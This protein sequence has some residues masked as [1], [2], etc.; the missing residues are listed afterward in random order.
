MKKLT[1]LEG[2]ALAEIASRGA[3]TSYV[4]AQTFA[5]SP[6]EFWSGSA[7]ALYPLIKRL[8]KRGLLKSKR[9]A[10]GKRQR[11]DY[12]VTPSGRAALLRWLLDAER[13][14]GMGFDPLRTRLVY[15]QLVKSVQRKAFLAQ[16]RTLSTAFAEKPAFE[17]LPL[18]QN[19]HASWLKARAQWLAAL[20]FVV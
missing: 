5:R 14:A 4:V 18:T 16:V 1:D 13:A 10:T 15:L 7:G 6:S 9:A 17:G 20:D 3:A 2:A 19:I 11:L 8:A 12:R